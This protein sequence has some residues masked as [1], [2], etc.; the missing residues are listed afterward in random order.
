MSEIRM[1]EIDGLVGIYG[2]V[3]NVVQT[4]GEARAAVARLLPLY[5]DPDLSWYEEFEAWL[6]RARGHRVERPETLFPSLERALRELAGIEPSCRMRPRRLFAIAVAMRAF[7]DMSRPDTRLGDSTTDALKVGALAVKPEAAPGLQELLAN[8]AFLPGAGPQGSQDLAAWWSNLVT[9]AHA[10]DLLAD[11]RGMT[12]RP[13]A[14]RLV[15]VRGVCGPAAALTTDFETEEVAFEEAVRFIEPANWKACMPHFW[16]VMEEVGTGVAPGTHKYHEEVS[17]DCAS[18]ALAAFRAKTELDF[19]FMWVPQPGHAQVAIANYQ[20]SA[21][22]PRMCDT[23]RVDEGSLVVAKTRSDPGPLRITTTKRIQFSYPFS[24]EALAMIMCALGY[25]DVAGDLL[26]CAASK[27]GKNAA[28]GT[29]FPGEPPPR[30]GAAGDPRVPEPWPVLR[31]LGLCRTWRTCGPAPC[32]R[33]RRPSNSAAAAPAQ[34]SAADAATDR[35]A[36]HGIRKRSRERLRHARLLTA[37]PVERPR[38][39]GGVEGRRRLDYDAASA[40][41][42]LGTWASLATEDQ[43]PVRRGGA[44]CRFHPRRRRGRTERR[45]VPDLL[46]SRGSRS[47]ADGLALKGRT[48]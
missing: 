45:Q 21:G 27:D 34:W 32:A 19:N 41:A 40:A 35:R 13:C 24:S 8:D 10:Q 22:R 28:V 6:N 4:D 48:P 39:R 30:P 44:R 14:G 26:C 36:D 33:A 3:D 1:S 11:T 12:P 17:S 38:L 29:E 37:R 31:P 5:R 42:D 47:E 43:R 25:A 9:M 15:K 46:R 16:C 2:A 23:I 20:L 18:R 7:P